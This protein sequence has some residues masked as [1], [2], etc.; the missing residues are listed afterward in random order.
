MPLTKPAQEADVVVL[1][2]LTGE[3]VELPKPPQKPPHR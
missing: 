2:P 3:L 1:N